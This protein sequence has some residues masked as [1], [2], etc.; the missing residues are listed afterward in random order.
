MADGVQGNGTKTL[1]I[2]DAPGPD[3]SVRTTF[4]AIDAGML[5][6]VAPDCVICR[7]FATDSDAM[8]VA[9]TLAALGWRGRLLV[10]APGLPNRAMVQRELQASAPGVTIEVVPALQA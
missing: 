4:G 1:V 9:E 6:R 2:G 3:V 8:L 10:I 7:L 5:G